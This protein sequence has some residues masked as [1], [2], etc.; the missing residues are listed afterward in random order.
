M[1]LKRL[2]QFKS[3]A[4]S[5]Y[6]L[7]T[8]GRFIIRMYLHNLILGKNIEIGSLLFKVNIQGQ[9]LDLWG[10]QVMYKFGCGDYNLFVC[11]KAYVYLLISEVI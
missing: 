3:I 5:E 6:I 9:G 10:S 2:I 7:Q 11:N 8:S 4:F 1:I